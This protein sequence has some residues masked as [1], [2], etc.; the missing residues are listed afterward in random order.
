MVIIY[1][2]LQELYSKLDFSVILQSSVKK[3]DNCKMTEKSKFEYIF[4]VSGKPLFITEKKSFMTINWLLCDTARL[5][6]WDI[7][8]LLAGPLFSLLL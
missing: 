8:S 5:F 7:I 2:T 6:S 3:A 1:S 4:A